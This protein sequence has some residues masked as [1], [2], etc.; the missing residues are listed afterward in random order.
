MFQSR[1]DQAVPQLAPTRRSHKSLI[2]LL[3]IILLS[4]LKA[5][6]FSARIW[7]AINLQRLANK[8]N[9]APVSVS[10]G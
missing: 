6:C 7:Y 4:V 2:F 3:F 1:R 8:V 10:V 5:R 9:I